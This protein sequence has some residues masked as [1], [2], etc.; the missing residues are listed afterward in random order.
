ML[1]LP[2]RLVVD[3]RTGDQVAL[4]RIPNIFESVVSAKRA[5]RELKLLFCLKHLN[6]TTLIFIKRI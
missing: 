4:K 3:P 6:V 5:Y 2:C 1:L